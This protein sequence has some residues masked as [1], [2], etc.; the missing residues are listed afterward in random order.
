MITPTPDFTPQELQAMHR[1]CLRYRDLVRAGETPN[2]K[3]TVQ[4][5]LFQRICHAEGVVHGC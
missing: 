2:A 3:Q 5:M 4:F 1:Y